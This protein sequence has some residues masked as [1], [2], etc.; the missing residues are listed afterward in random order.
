MD[1]YTVIEDVFGDDGGQNQLTAA[2]GFVGHSHVPEDMRPSVRNNKVGKVSERPDFP[3]LDPRLQNRGA[4]LFP[5]MK[6]QNETMS[7]MVSAL[8][9]NGPSIYPGVDS[10]ACRDIF[11]HVENCPLCKSYFRHDAKFYWLII[12][13]LIVIILLITRNGK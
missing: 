12:G 8:V 2:R 4:P 13:I 7:P 5:S 3:E 6:I 9:S 11:T 1:S 10:L